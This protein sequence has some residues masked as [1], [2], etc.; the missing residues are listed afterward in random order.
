MTVK[1]VEKWKSIIQQKLYNIINCSTFVSL[2]YTF[3]PAENINVYTP[4]QGTNRERY[5]NHINYKGKNSDS[6]RK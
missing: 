6:G 4:S 2:I 3:S 5:F 1:W